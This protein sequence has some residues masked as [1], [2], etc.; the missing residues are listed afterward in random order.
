MNAKDR[1]ALADLQY[2]N[3]LAKKL[4][5]KLHGFSYRHTGSYITGRSATG[6]QVQPSLTLT[7]SE[8]DQIM[9][10][11]EKGTNERSRSI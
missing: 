3:A 10:A 11:I 1:E 9:E 7:G 4:G 2:W 5:W 6:T 8:R